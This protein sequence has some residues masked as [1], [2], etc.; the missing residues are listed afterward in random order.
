[1]IATLIRENHTNVLSYGYDFFTAASEEL[2]EVKKGFVVDMAF[3]SRVSQASDD[4]W[5]KF[6]KDHTP[7]APEKE[8]RKQMTRED[9]LKNM[10]TLKGIR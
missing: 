4:H 8:K 10:Q 2:A 5:K 3:A 6:M 7:K 9:H 1:M